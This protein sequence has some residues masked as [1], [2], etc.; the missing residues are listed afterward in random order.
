MFLL[1]LKLGVLHKPHGFY[2]EFFDPPHV[3]CQFYI[4][5]HG[6][7]LGF[8]DPLPPEVSTCFVDGPLG[9]EKLVVYA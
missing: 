3:R 7:F 1:N 6:F 4:S 5:E 9:Q 8:F 2:S